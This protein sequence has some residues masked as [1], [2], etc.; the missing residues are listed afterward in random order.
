M[1]NYGG[2]VKNSKELRAINQCDLFYPRVM[3]RKNLLLP[4]FLAYQEPYPFDKLY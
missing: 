2:V 1:M 4:T 3:A